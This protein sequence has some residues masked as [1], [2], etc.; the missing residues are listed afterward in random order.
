MDMRVQGPQRILFFLVPNFSMIAFATA[1]EPLRLAN[2]FHNE[3]AYDWTLVSLD[4]RPVEASNGVTIAVDASLSDVGYGRANPFTNEIVLV[5]SGLGV[6]RYRNPE[7]FAWLRRAKG[8]GMAVGGLCTGAWVL[9]EAG[10]LD[11]CRCAIHWEHLP[12]F[13]EKFPT[14]DVYSNLFEIDGKIYTCAG[15]TASLDMMLHI[16]SGQLGPSI[17]TKVCEQCLTDRVRSSEDRQRL[18]LRLRRGVN[19]KKLLF[20]IE[21]MEANIAEP[22]RLAEISD[23]ADLSRRHIER[24]FRQYLGQPPARFYLDLRLEY[25]RHLLL[26]SDLNI[27]DVAVACGFVSASHFSKCYR[28]RYHV[29][30]QGD[31]AAANM[32]DEPVEIAG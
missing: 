25:A 9:A 13:A 28:N 31:R 5:C 4:G 2:R 29:S 8:H 3:R 27:V 16:I 19:N 22:L 17:T 21:Q 12:G 6:E 24:M 32:V 15:G 11:G 7:L 14:A 26:Q 10:L 30:P 18:P 23:Q 1:I 20:I